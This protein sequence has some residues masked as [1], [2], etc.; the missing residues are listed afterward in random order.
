M[1]SGPARRPWGLLLAG[2]LLAVLTAL[3]FGS[4]SPALPG[5]GGP[6]LAQAIP[7]HSPALDTDE[8]RAAIAEAERIIEEAR[9]HGCRVSRKVG[10]QHVLDDRPFDPTVEEYQIIAPIAGG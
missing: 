6:R 10:D 8:N 7:P 1:L 5:L 2:V 9:R 3:A 4:D